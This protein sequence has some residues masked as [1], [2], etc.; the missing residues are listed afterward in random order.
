MRDLGYCPYRDYIHIKNKKRRGEREIARNVK[1]IFFSLKRAL[2]IS[3]FG[4]IFFINAI[5]QYS[6]CYSDKM[7]KTEIKSF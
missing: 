2:D 1:S 6:S 5:T 3:K 7:S 4:A